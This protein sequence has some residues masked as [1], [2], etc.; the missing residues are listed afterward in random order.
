[1]QCESRAKR[2]QA[3]PYAMMGVI[4]SFRATSE[5][6]FKRH[7]AATFMPKPVYGDNGSGMRCHQ[8]IWK[9]GS[10]PERH[11]PAPPARAGRNRPQQCD[12]RL[13]A[14]RERARAASR[15]REAHPAEVRLPAGQAGEGH[16]NRIGAGRSAHRGVGFGLARVLILGYCL[17]KPRTMRKSISHNAA[18][19]SCSR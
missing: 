15:A 9:A 19:Q 17:T 7:S 14:A 18:V 8:P 5:S 2:G 16:S 10:R 1:M 12:D 11:G 3:G 4:A 13:D 6:D